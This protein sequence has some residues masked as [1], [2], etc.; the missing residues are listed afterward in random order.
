ML[1]VGQKWIHD[2]LVLFI[3]NALCVLIWT[4]ILGFSVFCFKHAHNGNDGSST[5][6]GCQTQ[7]EELCVINWSSWQPF[8]VAI[9]Y[10]P[11]L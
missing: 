6:E 4:H 10:A 2:L 1:W 7:S 8:E 3:F 5:G 11:I 9:I